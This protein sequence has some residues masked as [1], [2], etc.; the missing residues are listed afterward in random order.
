[1]RV[2]TGGP[3]DGVPG[4]GK[5]KGKGPAAGDLSVRASQI[6]AGRLGIGL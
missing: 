3:E 4:R 6:W 1:M 2:T 5:S